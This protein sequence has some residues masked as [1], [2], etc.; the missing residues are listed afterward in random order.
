MK[1]LVGLIFLLLAFDGVEGL[2]NDAIGPNK[3]ST[4]QVTEETIGVYKLLAIRVT[5][6]FGQEPEESLQEIEAAIFTG[7]H[8]VTK[9]FSAI[10]HNQLVYEPA[11]SSG[12]LQIKLEK[13]LE[14]YDEDEDEVIA[15]V[16]AVLDV[17]SIT[18]VADRI[19]FCFPTGSLDDDVQGLAQKPGRVRSSCSVTRIYSRHDVQ[20]SYYHKGGCAKLW[21]MMHELGHNLRFEHSGIGDDEYQDR[22]G[23]MGDSPSTP[24]SFSHRLF[25]ALGFGE[26]PP[27]RRAF[28]RTE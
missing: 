12:V 21:V 26:D 10:S 20:R 17:S 25:R 16:E 1:S 9:Q 14:R 5:S 13:H 6:S 2:D 7:E 23:Y 4:S 24:A 3:V 22:S 28:V 18:D 15:A 19:L 8:S 11:T 27:V